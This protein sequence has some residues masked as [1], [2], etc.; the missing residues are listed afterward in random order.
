MLKREGYELIVGSSVDPQFG[1][2]ILFGTGGELVEVF[3]DRA[4]A[5]PPLNTTLARRMMEQTR[6]F[7]ALQGV[8]GRAA[9]D[10]EGLEELL[11]R[12][13]QLV[14]EQRWIKEIDVNP[15]LA[16]GDGFVALDARVVLY[17]SDVTEDKLPRFAVRPYPIQYAAS[18]T[19]KNAKPLTI[20]P[21]RP[22]DEPLM[23]GFHQKLSERTVYLRY[24]Q[25]LKLSQRTAHERLRRIC[26]S[27][28][29]REM[30]LVGEYCA[31]TGAPEIIAV[32]R[33]SKLHARDEAELAVLVDDRFQHM[34]I[35]TELYRRLI[36]IAQEE[37]VKRLQCTV[38]TENREMQAICQ[39]LGFRLIA[40]P[41]EGTVRAE[42]EL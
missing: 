6:I 33:L 26:F 23:V 30:V 3:R 20:R 11:V 39:K 17:G 15:L 14:V 4:L 36:H 41:D 38:L 40:D 12:F 19:M 7:E 18:W 35:G 5:L 29:D 31:G 42:L 13:S 27:D 21:I 22:E 28:Y 1:P 10:I 34:G 32:G 8:R 2:V 16:S 37:K 25:P 24:F 9:V